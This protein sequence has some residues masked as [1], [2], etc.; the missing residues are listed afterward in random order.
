MHLLFGND[1]RLTGFL[2]KIVTRNEKEEVEHHFNALRLGLED[3]CVF[4]MSKNPRL[5][6][7]KFKRVLQA[8]TDKGDVYN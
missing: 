7:A 1:P 5:F 4:T 6:R 2:R 3:N 8:Q